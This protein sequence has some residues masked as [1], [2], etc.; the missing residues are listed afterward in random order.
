MA[1]PVVSFMQQVT[2]TWEALTPPTSTHRPYWHVDEEPSESA[3]IAD[4]GFMWTLPQR[5]E[6]RGE[7]DGVTVLVEWLVTASL[8]V[9]RSGRGFFDFAS[10]VANEGNQLT[11]ALEAQTSWPAGVVEFLTQPIEVEEEDDGAMVNLTFQVLV[12]ETV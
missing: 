11:L 8:F 12:E 1:S 5:Q 6:V 4:R 10:A 7:T 2:T 3:A 9:A